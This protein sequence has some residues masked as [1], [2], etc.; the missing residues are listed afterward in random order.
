MY[1]RV[2]RGKPVTSQFENLEIK[3]HGTGGAVKSIACVAHLAPRRSADVPVS[4][5]TFFMVMLMRDFVWLSQ[6]LD[7]INHPL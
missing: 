3:A 7:E 2:Q 6:Q 1:D 5:L 4:P